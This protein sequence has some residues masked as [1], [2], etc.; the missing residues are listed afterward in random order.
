[1]QTRSFWMIAV[2]SILIVSGLGALMLWKGSSDHKE[3]LILWCAAALGEPIKEIV[4]LYEQEKGVRIEVRYGKSE[5]ILTG[6]KT[7]GQGDIFLPADDSYIEKAQQQGLLSDSLALAKMHAVLAI[8]G[9]SKRTIETWADLFK[10]SNN[11]LVIAGDGAAIR[12]LTRKHLPESQWQQLVAGSTS[13]GTV[14]DVANAI[15]LG[16]AADSGI[17]WDNMLSSKNYQNL[18]PVKLKELD[19]ITATVKVGVIKGSPRTK[20]AVAFANFISS[21][22]GD[23]LERHGF[24]VLGN[25]AI[26]PPKTDPVRSKESIEIVLF[27]GSMLRPAIEETIKEFEKREGVKV[28]TNY[29]GCGILVSQMKV[30]KDKSDPAFPDLYFSCDTTFMNQVESLFEKPKSISTNQ[31]VIA[32]KKGNPHGIKSLKDLGKEGLQVGVGHEQQCALGAITEGVLIRSKTYKAVYS[33]IAVRSPS[34]D[35]LVNQLRGGALDAAIVYVSNAKPWNDIEYVKVEEVNCAPIQP[36]AM[37]KTTRH[38]EI[39]KRLIREIES[40]Q[41]KERFEKFGFGWELQP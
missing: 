29:N 22:C 6:I 3:P 24:K 10:D 17:I 27:S 11:K 14:T 33:N 8:N 38:P 41:S 15:K 2:A 28:L 1:M 31:L 40:T 12:E 9:D 13:L 30:L 37:S 16:G 21:S 23:I 35:L 25:P 7:T 20:D 39:V 4:P 36:I 5:E 18:K 32:T 34:G 19:G 26:A